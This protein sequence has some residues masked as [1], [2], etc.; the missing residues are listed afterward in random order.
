MPIARLT[1]IP[2]EICGRTALPEPTS[3]GVVLL[4]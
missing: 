4:V 1:E 2:H 3:H